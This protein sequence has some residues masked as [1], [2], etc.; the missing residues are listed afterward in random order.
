[1]YTWIEDMVRKNLTCMGRLYFD[2]E[3]HQRCSISARDAVPEEDDYGVVPNEEEGR[4]LDEKLD[5]Y[6]GRI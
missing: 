2:R 6:M 3:C 5:E 1:M 4:V